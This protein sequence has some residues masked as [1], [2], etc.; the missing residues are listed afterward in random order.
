MNAIQT[1]TQANSTSNPLALVSK[2]KDDEQDEAFGSELAVAEGM[3]TQAATQMLKSPATSIGFASAPKDKESQA[4]I[5]GQA[6]TV[7]LQEGPNGALQT[8]LLDSRVPDGQRVATSLNTASA[9]A[10]LK[11]WT[12]EWIMQ[13]VDPESMKPLID[14]GQ[15]RGDAEDVA[16]ARAEVLRSL[17]RQVAQANGNP[18]QNAEASNSENSVTAHNNKAAVMNAAALMGSG[19]PLMRLEGE[20][21]EGG[22]AVGRAQANGAPT[23][24]LPSTP[25]GAMSGS[26]YLQT[27]AVLDRGGKG[28]GEGGSGNERG[29]QPTL[30]STPGLLKSAAKRGGAEVKEF[31][32]G[33]SLNEWA[34]M[35]SADPI[36]K[37]PLPAVRSLDA[38]VVSGSMARPRLS[39]ATVMGMTG[40]LKMLGNQGGGAMTLR[41]KPD[42]LGELHLRVSTNATGQVALQ[43]RASDERAKQVLEDSLSSLR[44]SMASQNLK[45]ASV[46]LAVAT[47]VTAGHESSNLGQSNSQ[48]QPDSNNYGAAWAQQEGMRQ[49]SDGFG[50][51]RNNANQNLWDSAENPSES[52]GRS[53]ARVMSPAAASAMAA[54]GIPGSGRLDVRG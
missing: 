2:T 41:L 37:T 32:W 53:S 42:H 29:A 4:V 5:S 38:Q 28:K 31:P 35:G 33:G 27:L 17:M 26:D 11:P 54:A 15:P 10:G 12:K 36:A 1:T 50:G 48:S 40:E 43:I 18:V 13:G 6:K 16:A 25:S 8:G 23:D 52:R 3:A 14:S 9:I 7:K 34:R 19:S 46:D 49:Y 44:D 39:T 45:L 51:G 20:T 30:T 21:E 47:R 24:A 22:S